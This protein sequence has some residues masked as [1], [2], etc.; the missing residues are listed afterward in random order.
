MR[1]IGIG[2]GLCLF[3]RFNEPSH[4]MQPII[5]RQ[6]LQQA[7]LLHF[8]KMHLRILPG[9]A[10]PGSEVTVSKQNLSCRGS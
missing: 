4:P 5:I 2:E 3:R 8:L 10:Y 1:I 6:R 7:I 9:R